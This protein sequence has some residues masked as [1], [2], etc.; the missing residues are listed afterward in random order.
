MINHGPPLPSQGSPGAVGMWK[1]SMAKED[2]VANRLMGPL[3][4][5]SHFFVTLIMFS[6]LRI[7]FLFISN[8][9]KL[10]FFPPVHL[11]LLTAC[12]WK[13]QSS[14]CFVLLW[15]WISVLKGRTFRWTRVDLGGRE[16]CQLQRLSPSNVMPTSAAGNWSTK[17]TC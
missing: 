16:A 2:S 3:T 17:W 13:K 12:S 6:I 15:I 14:S 1:G 10:S 4:Q 7:L 8:V 11:D 5:W 9:N